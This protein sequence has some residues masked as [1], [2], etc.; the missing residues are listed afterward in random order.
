MQTPAVENHPPEE[1]PAELPSHELPEDVTLPEPPVEVEASGSGTD[2]LEDL[3]QPPTPTAEE[4]E[5][6]SLEETGS[7]DGLITED[8]TI[9]AD[10]ISEAESEEVEVAAVGEEPTMATVEDEHLDEVVVNEAE[11]PEEL[12]IS[13]IAT[14]TTE[15]GSLPA[16]VPPPEGVDVASES[17]EPEAAETGLLPVG[18]GSVEGTEEETNLTDV[19]PADE[20][21][22]PEPVEDADI[23]VVL[24]YPEEPVFEE[25]GMEEVTESEGQE[26]KVETAA[27]APAVEDETPDAPEISTE[28]LTEDEIL[29]VDKDE[30]EPP[31]MD[32]LSPPQPTALSP[33]RESPFTRISDVEPASEGQPDIII[34]SLV[35]VKQKN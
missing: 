5:E 32:S 28:D 30:L 22:N 25:G 31:V 23:N 9:K 17:S 12:E 35:E 20:E 13:T 27:E 18:E 26:V 29:L 7:E 24:T 19:P 4:E 6:V 1:L 33:E 34:P 10:A 8:V 3:L 2:D 21:V 16:L 15:E 11:T 14:E